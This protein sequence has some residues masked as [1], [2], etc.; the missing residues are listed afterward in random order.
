MKIETKFDIGDTLYTAVT[1]SSR[2]NISIKEFTV[3]SIEYIITKDENNKKKVYEY[4]VPS[5]ATNKRI[6]VSKVF[7]TKKELGQA[8]VDEVFRD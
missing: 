8:I 4:V 3:D 2:N 5:Y 6:E 1:Y 7:K